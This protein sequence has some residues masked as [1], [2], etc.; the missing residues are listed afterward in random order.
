MSRHSAR[1]KKPTF[2]GPIGKVVRSLESEPSPGAQEIMREFNLIPHHLV[3][4]NSPVT[5]DA[6]A[7]GTAKRVEGKFATGT[8]VAVDAAS[9]ILHFRGKPC[10]G[11]C[12]GIMDFYVPLAQLR[13]IGTKP[14][15]N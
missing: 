13:Q 14:G 11:P 5:A 2:S 9:E 4:F 10:Q 15:A 12:H 8:F 1:N 7:L 3:V 6:W